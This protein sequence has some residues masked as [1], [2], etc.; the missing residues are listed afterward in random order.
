MC[1]WGA[2]SSALRAAYGFLCG[3]VY[4][5]GSQGSCD[6]GLGAFLAP[7]HTHFPCSASLAHFPCSLRFPHLHRLAHTFSATLDLV[8]AYAE[9]DLTHIIKHHHPVNGCQS[10]MPELTI[11]SALLQVLMGVHYLHEN[12]ILHLDLKPDNLLVQTRR[13]PNGQPIGVVKITDFG[14]ARIF[15]EPTQPL[16]NVESVVV[17]LWYRSPE[18]LLNAKHFTPAIDVWA[19]GCIFAEMIG[20]KVLFKGLELKPEKNQPQQ[21]SSRGRPKPR[22]HTFQSDQCYQCVS[23]CLFLCL[24]LRVAC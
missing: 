7:S 10:P 13:G 6:P 14:L 22:P 17:T 21:A 15:K 18:L 1:V 2:K 20:A 5:C 24:C 16:C 8:F 11:K 23:L 3:A 19:V 12:W 9:W 4:S